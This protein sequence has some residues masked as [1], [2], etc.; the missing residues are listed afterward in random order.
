VLT[1]DG[2]KM[3]VAATLALLVPPLLAQNLRAD[4]P[5]TPALGSRL[6]ILA[7]Q[8]FVGRLIAQD[9]TSLT[10]EIKRRRARAVIPRSAII[11]VERSLHT[12][13]K[14]TGA[15]SGAL[16]G[17]LSAVMLGFVVGEDCSGHA[18][19]F[20]Y[21][22]AGVALVTGMILVP[23]GTAIGAMV[24]PGER[25]E[26]IPVSRFGVSVAPVRGRGVAVSATLRF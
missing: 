18:G 2:M 3:L 20:C 23:L 25:W 14:G 24:A 8:E 15:M 5:A 4:D 6:R 10:L 9:E 17:A 22:P 11:R 16:F 7:D 1:A 13:K 26:S 12:S 21:P 19:L